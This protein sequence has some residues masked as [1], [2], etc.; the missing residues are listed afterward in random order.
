MSMMQECP[1]G[2][3]K[4]QSAQLFL[5]EIPGICNSNLLGS[6][7]LLKLMKGAKDVLICEFSGMINMLSL[8][9]FIIILFLIFLLL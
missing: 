4:T 3:C 7:H 9:L 6:F 2:V 8:K 5:A 1:L